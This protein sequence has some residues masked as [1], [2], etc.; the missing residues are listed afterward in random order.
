MRCTKGG[1]VREFLSSL[2]YKREELAAAGVVVTE[3]EY[4]RTILCGIPSDLAT[5]ASHLLSSALIVHSSA[6]INID[7]LI[8][9]INE[10][11]KRLKSRRTRG[12]G[13]QGGKKEGTTD[14]ALLA[15][16]S[17]GGK[18]RRCKG[19]CHNCGKAE[20]WARECRSPKKEKDESE[21]T[22]AAQTSRSTTPKPENK[23]VGSANAITVNE[24]EGDGFWMAED[25]AVVPAPNVS[26]EPDPMLGAP[27]DIEDAPHSEEEEMFLSEEEWF[28]AV[29]TPGDETDDGTR[30]ELYNS[31]ATRHISPY[32]ADFT[33]YAPLSPPVFLNTAN[34]QRFPAVGR[35]TLVVRVPNEGTESELTLHGALHA[36]AVSYTL[37]S[38]A[39][40]D[41]EGYHAHIGA[42]HFVLVSPQGVR[43]GRIPRTQGRLYKVVHKPDSANVIEPVSIMEMHRRMG[44][45][46]V[47]SARE[48]VESGAAVGVK[49]DPNSQETECDACIFA[50]A[51]RLPIPK[52]RISPPAQNFGDEVHTDVWG[53]SRIASRQGRRYFITFMDDATRYT[54]T[55]MMR[56]KDEAV[57]ASAE[58]RSGAPA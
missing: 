8:N 17:E 9:Q 47:S 43:I 12:Q 51:T 32:K 57:E 29:I 33:S 36:S 54:I 1:D 11:A 48:L 23:P 20:H 21:G 50:R 6:S 7:A 27:D 14:E 35:G 16:S 42:G 49:L 56:T 55:F 41:Q 31:G 39:A 10:E 58:R 30:V 28:G 5:F 4:K 40:L 45:I 34:Q 53:P 37:V 19:T 26:A 24:Y 46:A 25:E 22:K 52:V 38:I 18:K 3:K 15:T 2:C 44:H 13:G